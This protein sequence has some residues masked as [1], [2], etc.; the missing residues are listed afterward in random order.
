MVV[1]VMRG[2]A[3][4]VVTAPRERSRC[5][6]TDAPTSDDQQ[7]E[8][9]VSHGYS[10]S[11]TMNAESPSVTKPSAKT[12]AVCAIVTVPPRRNA[13]RGVPFVP[14]RYAA[15]IALPWPGVSA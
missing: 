2:G 1:V 12:P 5:L 6:R 9:S 8:T 10:C 15:T 13:S 3:V 4:V 7:P 11:G 14:T